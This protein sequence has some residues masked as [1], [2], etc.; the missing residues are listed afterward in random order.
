MGLSTRIVLCR[1]F[2]QNILGE[3]QSLYNLGSD[4]QCLQFF[5]RILSAKGKFL[6]NLNVSARRSSAVI[7][8]VTRYSSTDRW[9]CLQSK[10]RISLCLKRTS[11]TVKPCVIRYVTTDRWLPRHDH[12]RA[13]LLL[14]RRSVAL[15]PYAIRY[16]TMGKLPYPQAAC[17]AT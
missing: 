7:P 4:M 1:S 2:N 6:Y 15:S 14:D 5:P 12:W 3:D 8:C 16:A 10:K 13:R 11:A 9:P 17:K